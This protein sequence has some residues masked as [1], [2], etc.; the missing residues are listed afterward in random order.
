MPERFSASVANRHM[1][2]HASADLANAI[3][4]WVPPVEDPD[5]NTAANRGTRLHE[6]FAELMTLPR[7]D[8]KNFAAALDYVA[9]VK[10]G[11]RFKQLVE[12]EMEVSWLDSKPRTTA[13]LVLYVKD[14]IHV[15]DL[16]TGGIPVEVVENDQLMYYAVTYGHLAPKAKGVNVHIVQPWADNMECWFATSS[17]LAQF[18]VD[19]RQAERAIHNGSTDFLPGDHCTF[20]AANPRGRGAKGRPFCP[21]LMEMYYP[22][23]VDEDAILNEE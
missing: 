8:A 5:A 10:Q 13:D 1:S 6:I 21:A 14:E 20:C 7:K 9:E 19:A 16:K 4:H 12:T 11:R 15:L 18:V 23:I 2:C 22:M 17:R 3:P